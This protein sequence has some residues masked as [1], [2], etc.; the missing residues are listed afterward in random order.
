MS[1]ANGVSVLV[2]KPGHAAAA[3]WRATRKIG[4][5]RQFRPRRIPILNA[6]YL[7]V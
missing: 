4:D 5:D 7:M 2:R 1:D 3:P 6:V